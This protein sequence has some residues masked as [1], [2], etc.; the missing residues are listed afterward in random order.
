M[1]CYVASFSGTMSLLIKDSVAVNAPKSF[2]DVQSAAYKVAISD[3]T[4]STTGQYAVYA[5]ALALG[6]SS[7]DLAPGFQFFKNL[8]QQGRLTAGVSTSNFISGDYGVCFK[9]DFDSLKT[10]DAAAALSS[11][12]SLSAC[13]PTDGSV[14]AGYATIINR[15]A[16][17]PY[18]A[19]LV[20]EYILSDAGQ[21]NVA[22]GYATPIRSVKL[23]E[24][25]ESKRIP[26]S[27][28]N[29]TQ[30]DDGEKFTVALSQK[31][32]DG[33]TSQVVPYLGGN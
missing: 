18:A 2:A 19:L 20:R 32:I 6:G 30:I 26:R 33:W 22:K 3:V 28:Y 29:Q 15:S 12:V 11:P 25:L 13:I 21:L 5:A 4:V 10:R 17:N 14:T 23:P 27:Q 31:I 16:V 8:A 7:T 24:E 1:G 9:W